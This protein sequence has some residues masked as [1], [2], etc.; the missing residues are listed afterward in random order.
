MFSYGRLTVSNLQE[1]TSIDTFK[2]KNIPGPWQKIGL[3]V[4]VSEAARALKPLSAKVAPSKQT[5]DK[6]ASTAIIEEVS[7][8]ESSSVLTIDTL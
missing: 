3:G 4:T 5:K 6:I 1:R 2:S 7:D 8:S